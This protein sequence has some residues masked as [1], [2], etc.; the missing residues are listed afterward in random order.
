[1]LSLSSDVSF[2][3][4]L[5]RV[6]SNA[7]YSGADV[8]EVL[9]AASQITPGDFESF[10]VTFAN[11]ASR[12]HSQAEAL[13]QKSVASRRDFYL[14]AATY[15][16]AA[17]FYLHGNPNDARINE[18]QIKSVDL[19]EKARELLSY[20]SERITLEADGFKIPAIIYR[21]GADRSKPLPTMIM[22]SGFDGSQEELMHVHGFAALER[23]YN[24]ITYEGPGQP[25]VL[26]EQN[27]GFIAEWEKAVTPVVDF[28]ISQPD[29]DASK[30]GLL[31][32]SM[33]GYLAVRAAAFDHRIAAVIANDAVYDVYATFVQGTP[34]KL[35]GLLENGQTE[36]YDRIIFE[37]GAMQQAS[38]S[39][40]WGFEHGLYS[41]RTSSPA[42]LLQRTKKMTLKGLADKVKCPVWLGNA[43]HDEFFK[44]QPEQ[45]KEALGDKGKLV[46]LTM[47]DAAGH[48]CH[49]GATV[50]L[51]QIVFDWFDEVTSN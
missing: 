48:H 5:L 15:F 19:F 8:G 32:V 43:E 30:I 45:A 12:V 37:S 33:G 28:A 21:P 11:L 6:L 24:L 46:T 10:A 1:M 51:N 35:L 41:F 49:L 3:F 22:A 9:Q 25:T 13:P 38:T 31:G 36:E 50:L 2:H 29:V 26:R 40:R 16:R 42:A 44:G 17:D 23:G 39:T 7:R 47:E 18:Y 34:P 27:L 14:R 4:E 20:P